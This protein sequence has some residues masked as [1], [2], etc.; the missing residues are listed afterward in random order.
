[1]TR[2]ADTCVCHQTMPCIARWIERY[3]HPC[4]YG[5]VGRPRTSS[6]TPMRGDWEYHLVANVNGEPTVLD[7]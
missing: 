5:M 7:S 4:S 2:H 1:M 3:A 6:N